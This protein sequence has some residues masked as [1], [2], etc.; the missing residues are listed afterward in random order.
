MDAFITEES[1]MIDF[2]NVYLEMDFFFLFDC[3]IEYFLNWMVN[4]YID[5]F[6]FY[7]F[8]QNYFLIIFSFFVFDRDIMDIDDY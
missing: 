2:I 3:N 4:T 1:I 6:D 7:N 8:Y 5:S